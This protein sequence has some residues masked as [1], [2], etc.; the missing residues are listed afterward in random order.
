M[1]KKEKELLEIKAKVKM[2]HDKMHNPLHELAFDKESNPTEETNEK[3]N[4]LL[5][6]LFELIDI[7]A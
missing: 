6:A 5:D 7:Y 1:N 3:Y 4:I 2:I